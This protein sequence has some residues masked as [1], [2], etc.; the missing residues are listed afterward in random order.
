[1]PQAP[2]R[3]PIVQPDEPG[4]AVDSPQSAQ[5]G[6]P[7]VDEPSETG[8]TIVTDDGPFATTTY[9]TQSFGT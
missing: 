6:S 8:P 7:V 3:H 5:P 9:A 1:M 4:F 2:D